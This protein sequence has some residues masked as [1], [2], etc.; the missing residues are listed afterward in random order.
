MIE[1]L[2]RKQFQAGETIFVVGDFGD[3]A[4]L[5]ER[6]SVEVCLN[7]ETGER[8]IGTLNQGELFGEIALVDRLPRT[9][10]VRAIEATNL[11]VIDRHIVGQLLEK[12]DPV[13]RLLLNVILQRWR[14]SIAS[15]YSSNSTN[16]KENTEEFRNL[17]MR[18]LIL[19]N[20]ID[21]A[22]LN[23]EF[24]M[25]YQPIIS[26]KEN[27]VAGFEALIR[28]M[29][30]V[31]GMIPPGDFLDL[32]EQ[33]GQIRQIGLWT[34][35]QACRDWSRLKKL[36]STE[37]SFVSV[38]VSANQLNDPILFDMIKSILHQNNMN[39]SDL[40]LELTE[41]ALIKER[42]IAEELLLKL[43]NYG[44]SWALDDF[45]TGYS[46]LSSLQNYPIGTLKVDRSFVSQ[47]LT[48]S[49]SMQIVMN[50]MGLAHSIGIDVVAEGVETP[51][52]FNMLHQFGCEYGQGWLFGK[53]QPIEVLE[54]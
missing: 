49:L 23:K 7:E 41:T 9:A 36:T 13:I 51:D 10:T 52:T 18:N 15:I 12:T 48:S 39:P 4:F 54:L 3:C 19:S 40:K 6:G 38:N 53:P 32:A 26:L 30:P 33:T 11:V 37:K 31:K 1:D 24:V 2:S 42:E 22:L 16:Q 27:K 34:L 14:N 28:W 46:S 44:V 8:R 47:M 29:D 35:E 50:T 20:E 25:F 5:I 17:A 21:R 43:K 45:G